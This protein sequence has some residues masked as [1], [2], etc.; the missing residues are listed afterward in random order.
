LSSVRGKRILVTGATGGLGP[1]L[2]EALLAMGG[3]VLA[4]ARRRTRLDDLRA[5]LNH[6]DRLHVAECD[7]TSA[8]GVRALM[9]SYAQKGNIDGVVHAAGA[10]AYGDL[11]SQDDETVERLIGTNLLATTW[12]IREAVT[13]MRAQ[14]G[15]SVVVIAADTVTSPTRGLAVYG[16]AKAGAAHLVKAVAAEVK[17]AGVRVNAVLPGIIDT[18]DNRRSMPEADPAGWASPG[19]VAR[20]V[21]WLASD[22]AVGVT[23]TWLRVPGD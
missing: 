8:D 16:A 6:H 10:F 9:E 22:D 14:G 7:V 20:A 19:A 5:G 1:S 4:A 11:E 2:C 23:G 13:R 17:G 15:G 12:V 21:L 18:P 3:E